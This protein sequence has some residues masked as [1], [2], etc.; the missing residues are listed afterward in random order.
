MKIR[1]QRIV[2][3]SSQVLRWKRVF[4]DM[5]KGGNDNAKVTWPNMDMSPST[6]ADFISDA[7]W[8]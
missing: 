2:I 4:T 8:K 1:K 6:D 7:K 5:I 3:Y